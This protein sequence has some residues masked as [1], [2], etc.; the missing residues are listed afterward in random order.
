MS[1]GTIPEE[2]WVYEIFPFFDCI[3]DARHISYACTHMRNCYM[4][5]KNI[6]LTIKF[7]DLMSSLE[8]LINY[9]LQNGRKYNHYEVV[10]GAYNYCHSCECLQDYIEK[11]DRCK[12]NICCYASK[13]TFGTQIKD[14][15]IYDV[16]CARNCM[17]CGAFLCGKCMGLSNIRVCKRCKPLDNTTLQNKIYN[18]PQYVIETNRTNHITYIRYLGRIVKYTY[19]KTG[20]YI[21]QLKEIMMSSGEILYKT[22]KKDYDETY[23]SEW[24]N[25]FIRSDFPTETIE[26]NICLYSILSDIP[27]HHQYI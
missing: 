2:I 9:K 1:L 21:G 4:I 24:I 7:P 14:K 16:H 18:H 3:Q 26:Y 12:K 6:L 13:R 17:L 15:L 11:C 5:Y 8:Q 22:I 19:F 20:D 27:R 10:D 23:L 25:G